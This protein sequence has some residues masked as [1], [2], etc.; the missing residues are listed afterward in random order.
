[1][2]AVISFS[3]FVNTY[4]IPSLEITLDQCAYAEV[5]EGAIR[6]SIDLLNVNQTMCETSIDEIEET[7]TSTT[8]SPVMTVKETCGLSEVETCE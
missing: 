4:A 3:S 8:C 2:S 6:A 5:R 1:M 7:E